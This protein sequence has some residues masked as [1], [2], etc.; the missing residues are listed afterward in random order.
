M[1]LEGKTETILKFFDKC[2][3]AIADTTHE[4]VSFSKK[5]LVDIPFIEKARPFL[6]YFVKMAVACYLHAIRVCS[7]FDKLR[8]SGLIQS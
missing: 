8:T 2:C 5:G 1:P 6:L 7:P 4:E 3:H